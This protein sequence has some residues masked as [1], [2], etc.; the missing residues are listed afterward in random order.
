MG[1]FVQLTV[2]EGKIKSA[3]QAISFADIGVKGTMYGIA[4]K[5]AGFLQVAKFNEWRD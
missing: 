2:V 3:S 5:L 4:S 1:T